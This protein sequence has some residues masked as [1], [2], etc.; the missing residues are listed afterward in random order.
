MALKEKKAKISRAVTAER[1]RAWRVAQ[2]IHGLAEQPF[3]EHESS[4]LIADYLAGHG[5]DV[6][7]PFPKIPTAFR[8][9]W[10]SGKPVVGMLGEYDA[11]PNCG[12]REGKWGHGCG[13]NLLGTAPAL[14][15]VAARK[16]MEAERIR[17]TIVYYGC[18]AEETLAGKVYMAR[19]GGFRD[20]DACLAWHP[21]SGTGVNNAGGAALD[22]LVFE[23]F[24]K[25]AHG[26]GAHL[27]R[28][29]LDGVML[30][31]VAANYLR[32][33][34]PENVRIHSVIRHGGDAPNVVPAYAKSW[35]Y[36]RGKDRSQ[37]DEIRQRLLACARAAAAA[38]GT[39]MKWTRITAVTERLPNDAICDL[40][41]ENVKHFGPPRPTRSDKERLRRDLKMSPEFDASI[42][43]GRGSQGRGST[44]EDNVSWIAPLGRFQMAC[45]AKGTPGHH[46]D[47]A[48]QVAMPFAERALLQ[49]AKIFA[50]SA[51][52]LCTDP[53][54]LKQIRSEFRRRTR[55]IRYNPLIPKH[56]KV[57]VSPP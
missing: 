4:R 6:T 14:G 8:A 35:Y 5:F 49:A 23:Y 41:F 48:T 24:G 52:D 37:V 45:Y 15:A 33:H 53:V 54:S 11:L 10:G 19:D 30:L 13:H 36:V 47:L 40:V 31:D 28:S 55:G 7:F 16:I 21:A 27:G 3:Q 57:P 50:G 39:D 56:Q 44:D 34:V 51:L 18:P 38:T 1:S 20:L 22:S 2:Q 42:A 32:E 17:G 26:S 9:S 12:A 43:E 25:T 46:R 29:A